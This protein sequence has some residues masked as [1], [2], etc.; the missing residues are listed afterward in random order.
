MKGTE[1]VRRLSESPGTPMVRGFSEKLT[2]QGEASKG[3]YDSQSSVTPVR[4]MG[5]SADI[6][7][8]SSLLFSALILLFLIYRR[9]EEDALARRSRRA[10]TSFF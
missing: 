10:V 6:F 1:S 5:E 4:E 2:G 8:L 7:S 9:M 3:L